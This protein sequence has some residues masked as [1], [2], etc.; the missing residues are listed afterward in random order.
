LTPPLDDSLLKARMAG[1]GA[2]SKGDH[3][4]GSGGGGDLSQ[5]DV[6]D[7][8]YPALGLRKCYQVCSFT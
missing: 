4:A 6:S 8:R 3:R 7:G 1:L 2:I 5:F